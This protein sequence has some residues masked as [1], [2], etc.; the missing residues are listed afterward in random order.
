[1]ATSA[2][3]AS[4]DWG[5]PS[6]H[7]ECNREDLHVAHLLLLT[8]IAGFAAATSALARD[9]R[10]FLHLARVRAPLQVLEAQR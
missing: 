5:M 8:L 3:V 10:S 9:R 1:M 7:M 4:L 2:V 6:G